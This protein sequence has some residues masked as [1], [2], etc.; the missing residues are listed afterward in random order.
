[1]RLM[2]RMIEGTRDDLR[3][4]D[5]EYAEIRE[6][7]RVRDNNREIDMLMLIEKLSEIQLGMKA[8]SQKENLKRGVSLEDS[9]K[10]DPDRTIT[11]ETM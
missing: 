10:F 6:E 11:K 3:Q 1:M 4:R 5:R 2:Y 8:E 7:M 9:P